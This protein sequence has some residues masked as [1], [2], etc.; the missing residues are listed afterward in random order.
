[1]YQKDSI[2][3]FNHI[4]T[5]EDKL[6]FT[7]EPSFEVGLFFIFGWDELG[8]FVIIAKGFFDLGWIKVGS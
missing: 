6:S 2:G 7:S 4:R 5:S 3:N 1:M 8:L